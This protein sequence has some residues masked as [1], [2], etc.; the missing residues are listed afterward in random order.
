M[1]IVDKNK[2]IAISGIKNS[3]KTV[4]ITKLIPYIKNKGYKVATIKHDGHDFDCDVKNTD[5]YKH[6]SSG[7][8]ATAIFS[9]NK[10][11]IINKKENQNEDILLE[12]F[13]EMDIILLEGFK[14]SDYPKIEIIRKGISTESVC[15]IGTILAIATDIDIKIGNINIVDINDVETI[16]NIIISH[17]M[18]EKYVR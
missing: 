13:K 15:D 2:I 14:Y 12:H 7:A 1:N 8:N 11:M 5:T 4:L 18:G 9:K 6:L 16:G 17:T 10:Y 3:G